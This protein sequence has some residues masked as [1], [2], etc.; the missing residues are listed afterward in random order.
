MRFVEKTLLDL[1]SPWINPKICRNFA[2]NTIPATAIAFAVSVYQN[3]RA[4]K[5]SFKE[6]LRAYSLA[7]F[8][9][10][11]AVRRTNPKEAAMDVCITFINLSISLSISQPQP[12]REI[13][14][15]LG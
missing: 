2:A 4:E 13:R 6:R 11:D 1:T 5:T 3:G 9:S 14:S 8:S 10:F 7:I 12:M 15:F